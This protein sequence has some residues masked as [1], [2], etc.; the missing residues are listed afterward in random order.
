MKKTARH[1]AG[2]TDN[3]LKK[4]SLQQILQPEVGQWRAVRYNRIRAERE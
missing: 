2:F 4:R 3:P 1:P